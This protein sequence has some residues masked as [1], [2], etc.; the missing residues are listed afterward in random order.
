MLTC[1]VCTSAQRLTVTINITETK[2]LQIR[3]IRWC[4]NIFHIQHFYRWCIFAF[5]TA[6][7]LIGDVKLK[8]LLDVFVQKRKLQPSKA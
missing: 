6:M 1:I 2:M 3:D 8:M 5:R 7:R 4:R